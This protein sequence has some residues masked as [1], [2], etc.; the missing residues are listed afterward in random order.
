MSERDPGRAP[1]Y[2]YKKRVEVRDVLVKTFL[3]QY[4]IGKGPTGDSGSDIKSRMKLQV[5]E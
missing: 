3:E 2:E 5:H 4:D 1:S